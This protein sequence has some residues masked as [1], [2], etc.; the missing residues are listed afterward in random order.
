MSPEMWMAITGTAGSIFIGGM[1][2]RGTQADIAAAT[3]ENA[4]R[5]EEIK[6][7]RIDMDKR[8]NDH[9]DDN[10]ESASKFDSQLQRQ[11]SWQANHEREAAARRLE[12]Q[13]R[14]GKF[15]GA[16]ELHGSESKQLIALV[17]EVRTDVKELRKQ[18]N[19]EKS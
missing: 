1:M 4:A 9:I 8:V 7:L 13:T 14:M 10:K 2:W 5:A 19:K 12:V 3:K 16:L 17:T 11:W 18:M 15:E 6:Q